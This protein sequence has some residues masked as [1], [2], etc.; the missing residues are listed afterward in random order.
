MAVR[1]CHRNAMFRP[2]RLFYSTVLLFNLLLHRIGAA[3]GIDGC[4]DATEKQHVVLSCDR[5][6]AQGAL[7]TVRSLILSSKDPCLLNV[8]IVTES[9][10]SSFFMDACECIEGAPPLFCQTNFKVLLIPEGLYSPNHRSTIHYQRRKDLSSPLNY[11]RFYLH[12]VLPPSVSL[13][14]YIDCDVIVNADI[15]ELLEV[16]LRGFA[17]GFVPRNIPVE[18]PAVLQSLKHPV[19]LEMLEKLGKRSK[20]KKPS[21]P[22]NA[23]VMLLNVTLWKENRMTEEATGWMQLNNQLIKDKEKPIYVHGSQPPMYLV[24]IGGYAEL[25]GMW[26]NLKKTKDLGMKGI[27]HWNGPE[28]PWLNKYRNDTAWEAFRVPEECIFRSSCSRLGVKLNDTTFKPQW[29]PGFFPGYLSCPIEDVKSGVFE[30]FQERKRAVLTVTDGTYLEIATQWGRPFVGGPA[31]KW[32]C[33]IGQLDGSACKHIIAAGSP[34]TCLTMSGLTHFNIPEKKKLE[35]LFNP[36]Y[37]NAVKNRFF[38]IL[39]LLD[40]GYDVLYLDIDVFLTKA[41]AIGFL[42]DLFQL[43]HRYHVVMQDPGVHRERKYEGGVLGVTV[44]RANSLLVK[45]LR[46]FLEQ[47]TNPL[48]QRYKAPF[49]SQPRFFRVLEEVISLHAEP[50]ACRIPMQVQ[51]QHLVHYTG[52]Q[53]YRY[54]IACAKS[55]GYIKQ[56]IKMDLAYISC[57]RSIQVSLE[58]HARIYSQL[59]E[60]AERCGAV[61]VLHEALNSEGSPLSHCKSFDLAAFPENFVLYDHTGLAKESLNREKSIKAAQ[62][63]HFPSGTITFLSQEM[64]DYTGTMIPYCYKVDGRHCNDLEKDNP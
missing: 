48:F 20:V 4:F 63:C 45:H 2:S 41:S 42:S 7:T 39:M 51:N 36:A 60:I 37:T 8:Y 49:R 38:F 50:T 6:G 47:W 55:A 9:K 34:C 30:G 25:P 26:N 28:K 40:A 64:I 52:F 27:L 3:D 62:S 35:D 19:M 54:K 32:D 53:N 57:G 14:L 31:E 1:P 29:T 13:V 43:S 12:E 15:Q 22:F 59:I 24:F 21:P 33:F 44:Y 11:V 58:M 56:P 61:L 17:A 5:E 23:G 46:C 10:D 18:H 16:D